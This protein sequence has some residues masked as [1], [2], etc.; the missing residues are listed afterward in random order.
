MKYLKN[1]RSMLLT[2]VLAVICLRIILWAVGP[3]IP[4]M[5]SAI[6]FIAAFTFIFGIVWRKSS[7]L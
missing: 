5:V 1:A 6:I 3:L 4:Y 2:A 7:K